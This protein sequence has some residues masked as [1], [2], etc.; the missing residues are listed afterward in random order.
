MLNDLL[1]LDLSRILAGPWATQLLADLGARV[2]KIERPEKGDDTR[3]WGPPYRRTPDGKEAES[4]YYL[5]TNRGK[6]SVTVDLGDPRGQEIVRRL[7]RDADVLV[8]NFRA[9]RLTG[10]GLGYDDL[11]AANP[12]LIYCSITGFGQSGPLAGRSGYDAMIQAMGGLMSITGQ[13]DGPPQKVGVAVSDLMTGMYAVAAILAAVN[14]RHRTGRGRHLDV[15]LFDCQLGWLANQAMNYFVGGDSPGRLGSAHPNIV[16]YQNFQCADGWLTIAI[17]T[18]SQFAAWCRGAGVP[19]WADDG[20]FA[21]NAARVAHR[22]ELISRMEALI[23][24]RDRAYWQSLCDDAGIPC[25]PVNTVAEAFDE[26]QALARG[27]VE[28]W[29][30]PDGGDVDAP[31][32]PLR[33]ARGSTRPPALGE[34]TRDVLEELGFSSSEIG[35]LRSAGVV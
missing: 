19:E 30:F 24:D 32:N 25:G 21:T 2:I 35:A 6:E 31:A 4:A 23:R 27:M 29:T 26:P 16:P 34:Q 10:Y 1:I 5:A 33:E 13:P 22:T 3:A 12:G 11:A 28:R 15:A 8:E 9:G 7:V 17:G 18:D 20:R 14:E